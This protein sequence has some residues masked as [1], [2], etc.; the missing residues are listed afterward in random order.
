MT[1]YKH[2]NFT[3]F[4]IKREKNMNGIKVVIEGVKINS[5]KS[6]K[7]D[8]TYFTFE[9]NEPV[10]KFVSV[11]NNT[12]KGQLEDLAQSGDFVDLDCILKGN[13]LYF[14]DAQPSLTQ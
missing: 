3:N 10:T 4:V 5:F 6:K 14:V 11:Q 2:N 9:I 12:Q 13:R 1:T 8:E 7:S